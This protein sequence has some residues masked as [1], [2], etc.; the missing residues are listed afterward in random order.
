MG[1]KVSKRETR[2]TF[3]KQGLKGKIENALNDIYTKYEGEPRSKKVKSFLTV[4][5]EK[6]FIEIVAEIVLKKA[7]EINNEPI[8]TNNNNKNITCASFHDEQKSTYN[9]QVLYSGEKFPL[10]E[11]RILDIGF[12]SAKTNIALI[13]NDTSGII[14]YEFVPA[15]GLTLKEFKEV[16]SNKLSY[17]LGFVKRDRNSKKTTVKVI[18]SPP[19]N[20]TNQTKTSNGQ[21]NQTKTSNG[22]TNPTN[23]SNI[24]TTTNPIIMGGKKKRRVK[25]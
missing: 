20:Q 5:E 10:C 14:Y 11:F 21:K 3:G 12:L 8:Q 16:L 1:G 6:M 2:N 7:K 19:P 18:V 15:E 17:R 25:K 4:E 24:S 22:Q 23:T 13:K 9:L